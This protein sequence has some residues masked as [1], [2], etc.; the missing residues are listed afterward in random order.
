MSAHTN[1][2]ASLS[3][4]APLDL[5]T[6]YEKLQSITPDPILP[7]CLANPAKSPRGCLSTRQ[8]QTDPRAGCGPVTSACRRLKSIENS[9]NH[10][11]PLSWWADWSC[12]CHHDQPVELFFAM[13]ICEVRVQWGITAARYCCNLKSGCPCRE[14]DVTFGGRREPRQRCVTRVSEQ[15]LHLFICKY[16]RIRQ[17]R[18][19]QHRQNTAS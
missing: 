4:A 19:A 7:L 10:E 13:Q 11:H 17:T 1:M 9:Q 14:S 2:F 5:L 15:H 6:D 3:P 12:C 16:P 18:R 8:A